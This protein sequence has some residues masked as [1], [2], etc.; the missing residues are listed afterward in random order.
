MVAAKKR[1]QLLA[2]V[3]LVFSA[4]NIHATPSEKI[5]ELLEKHGELTNFEEYWYKHGTMTI[6]L[7]AKKIDN[8]HTHCQIR[9]KYFSYHNP[10]FKKFTKKGVSSFK[11]ELKPFLQFLDMIYKKIIS[12]EDFKRLHQEL[13][14]L[15]ARRSKWNRTQ[16]DNP[17]AFIKGCNSYENDYNLWR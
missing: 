5:F 1:F 14:P 10:A 12:D 7:L 15:T 16:L 11:E 13:D 8:Y 3:S 4:Q 2:Y 9:R 17:R 6:E